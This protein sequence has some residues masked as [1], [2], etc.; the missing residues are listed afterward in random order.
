MSVVTVDLLKMHPMARKMNAHNEAFAK[1]IEAGDVSEAK[2]HLG[3]ILKYANTLEEDIHFA[4]QK[5]TEVVTPTNGWEQQSPIIKFN[6]SGSKFN[7]EFR[8]RQL[9]GTI[10]SSRN[11]TGM[12]PARS[13]FGRRV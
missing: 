2:E 4:I 6:Q 10:L 13:T 9:P 7:P 5:S 1:A 11:N 8:D 3:E 12:R